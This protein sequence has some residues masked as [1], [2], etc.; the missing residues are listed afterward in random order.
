[1]LRT[2]APAPAMPARSGQPGGASVRPRPGPKRAPG[3]DGLRGLAVLAVL[4]FHEKVSALPGGFLGVDVFFAISGFL[5]TDILA[6]PWELGGRLDLRRFWLRRARRL[7]PC[8]LLV[9]VA[10]TAAVAV[11]EPSQLP[12]LRPALLAAVTYTSNWWQALAH[13]SYFAVFGPP[14][15]LQHLWSLAI[16]EQFYLL[17]PV[18]LTVILCVFRRRRAR[19]AAAGVAAAAS[20]LAMAAGYAAGADPS[21]LYYGTDTHATALLAG[22]ALALYCP[23][24]RLTGSSP[25]QARRLDLAGLA[26]VSVLVLAMGHL[27]GSSGALYLG[28]MALAAAAAA[29]VVAAAAAPGTLAAMIGWAPLRWLGV[30]SYGIYLWHWPVIALVTARD[31]GQ[32]STAGVRLA[33]TAAAVGLAA[34]SWRWVEEPV[35][36]DGLAATIRSRWAGL[37][38]SMTAA[39]RSPRRLVPAALVPIVAF[40][41]ACTAGYGVI[42]T[43]PGESLQQQIAAG[44]RVSSSSKASGPGQNSPG[45]AKPAHRAAHRGQPA[46]PTILGGYVTAIGDSVMLA[47]AQQLQADLPGIYI[48]AQVSRQMDEGIALV[49]ELAARHTLRPVVVVGLGTNGPVTTAQ[50]HALLRAIGPSRALVLVSTYVPRPWESEVNQALAAA[51]QNYPRVT[52]DN[53]FASIRDR[54]DLLWPDGVH[55]Q[56]RGAAL[57]ARMLASAAHSAATTI[58]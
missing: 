4:A 1:M 17:W 50:V 38:L 7:L 12:S 8:L 2:E 19:A 26:G 25:A 34:L 54:T 5:I 39:R 48:D 56:P 22:A 37:K 45:H 29:V 10:V 43:P 40:S 44:A 18:V 58:G 36:R 42:Y 57:Y 13:Q 11:L 52:L 51:A 33:E 21:R 31:G 20:A 41:V 46:A 14:P 27:S 32:A 23:L 28:G 53:W 16:E 47:S 30:R 15:P 3:L 49:R 9:L 24:R 6:A 35:I 55:P